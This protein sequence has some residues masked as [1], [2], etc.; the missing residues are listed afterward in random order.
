MPKEPER[1]EIKIE[2]EQKEEGHSTPEYIEPPEK[3]TVLATIKRGFVTE[4]PEDL[5]RKQ[6]RR[7]VVAIA[8]P[9]LIESFLLHLA[10]MV[11]TMM[12]GSLGPL[13]IAAVGF[14]NQPRL[15]MAS[16]F[17][18][19]NT[20]ST[21]LIARAKGAGNMIEANKVMHQAVLFGMTASIILAILG[22]VFA[23]NLIILMGASE[24]QTI[25]W[26]TQ[27]FQIIMLTFPANAFSL[28]VTA[29]LRGVGRT[30]VSLVYNMTANIV[31]VIVGFLLIQGRFG[32][33][34]LGVR[35][36]AIGLGAGQVI[37]AAMAL[38]III[39]GDG[40][41]RLRLKSLLK[42]DLSILKRVIRIGAP[43]MFEQ[44]CMRVGN[45]LFVRV[46]ASLG[47]VEFATHQIAMNVHQFTFMNGQAFGISAT[48]LLGQSLGRNRPDQGRA[49]VQLCRRYSLFLALALAGIIAIFSRQIV[50]LYI[51]DVYVIAL[52]S[53][54]LLIVAFLQPF[55]SSQQ[56]LA[57]ALRGAGDTKA[58]ALC[59]F[60]GVMVIRPV[61]SFAFVNLFTLGL[62]GVWLAIVLDQGTRSLYTMWRFISDK[63]RKIRV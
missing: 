12:V 43:A 54:L 41:L 50:G 52:G 5:D 18:A 14:C 8:W 40:M 34:A 57:G 53:T 63:W 42:I 38:V 2:E 45:I 6:A 37:A 33:P 36:A 3:P 56:V 62:V 4:F 44:L 47:D 27:Y 1:E 35:G 49:L 61:V 55:Q 15:L 9:A 10:S 21:A 31:N 19:F 30:R 17:M 32:L 46:V 59:I 22:S 13:A 48:S 51:D 58:V 60:I 39:R 26:A 11:N 23:R 16:V 24:P 29:M 7:D 20:G 28:A 25:E